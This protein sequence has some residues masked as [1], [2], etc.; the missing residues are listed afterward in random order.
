MYIAQQI[1]THNLG[2]MSLKLHNPFNVQHMSESFLQTLLNIH[3]PNLVWVTIQGACRASTNL[4]FKNQVSNLYWFW[5]T[6]HAHLFCFCLVQPWVHHMVCFS[7]MSV[8]EQNQRGVKGLHCFLCGVNADR[9]IEDMPDDWP[10]VRW[11]TLFRN[12]SQIN[13]FSQSQ[14][15]VL[16]S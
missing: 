5:E 6:P 1:Q 14:S 8:I 10:V 12:A 11:P 7:L 16:A 2:S 4:Y 15:K 9:C 13:S 3:K